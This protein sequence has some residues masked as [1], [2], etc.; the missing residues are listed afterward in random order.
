DRC[1]LVNLDAGHWDAL[2]VACAD[3]F[4]HAADL[5]HWFAAIL[6]AGS[7]AEIGA[8]LLDG[9]IPTY[10]LR[11]IAL[12]DD[13]PEDEADEPAANPAPSSGANAAPAAS[14]QGSGQSYATA[15]NDEEDDSE[16]AS[17]PAGTQRTS[18]SSGSL[19]GGGGAQPTGRDSA[20]GHDAVTAAAPG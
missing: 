6:K 18:A 7:P 13:T 2:A 14:S 3:P 16:E 12:P 9:G 20:A 5:R 17:G 15:D 8:I 4:R 19:G 11:E 10:R 1:W